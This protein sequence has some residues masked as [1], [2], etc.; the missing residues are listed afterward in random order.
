LK[1]IEI[2]GAKTFFLSNNLTEIGGIRLYYINTIDIN[3]SSFGYV[4][5]SLNNNMW[6]EGSSLEEINLSNLNNLRLL[7]FDY[8]STDFPL[9]LSSV[10]V[11]QL[12]LVN[13]S[14]TEL[15]LK[16]G[17]VIGQFQ[18]DYSS[19]VQFI[20]I[21]AD[22]FDEVSS[23]YGNTDSPVVIHPYCTFVLGGEYY[24]I[25]GNTLTDLGN[26]SETNTNG[27][28]FDIKFTVTD[29]E[30]TD[31]FYSDTSN[32]YS[33]TLPEGNHTLSSHLLN[34]DYWTVSPSSIDLD[35]PADGTPYVQDFCITP[36]GT[37]NDLEIVIVPI[38]DAQPGFE[39]NYKL[40]YKNS[41]TTILSGEINLNF[42]DNFTNFLTSSPNISNQTTGN[43]TWDYTDLLP[44]ETREISF[45]MLLNTPTDPD[46]PLNAEDVLTYTATINPMETDETSNNNT[47]TLNQ[48]V[49]N[50]FDPND[51]TCLEGSTIAYEQVGEY[52]HYR[53]RFENNGTANATNVVVKDILD[54]T[55]F[56][57]NSLVPINASHDFYT[58]IVNDNEVE[59]IFE[60]IQ[61]PFDNN[62]N[63][64]YILF[65][66]KTLPTLIMG[67]SFSNQ[68]EIFFDFNFPI[69]TNE[70]TTLIEEN[71]IT[72]DF[73]IDEILIF[74]NPTSSTL[75]I[76]ANT[77]MLNI[78]LYDISGK[79]LKTIRPHINNLEYSLN[80]KNLPNGIYFI[81]VQLENTIQKLKFIKN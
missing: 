73:N 8:F 69:L 25:T 61:L 44:F 70:E 31:T 66:I 81:E 40:I 21:D 35:F 75:N 33:Y 11:E 51:I 49:V 23:G 19:D 56:D 74:P 77:K 55:K 68:A 37:Y 38:N 34:L 43:L 46:F 6:I 30:S 14:L 79:L 13:C 5:S 7:R 36:T 45:S 9:D 80:V 27:P 72:T 47:F 67:D 52:V 48:I 10:E 63:D 26:G 50:S 42:N 20:C 24:E 17:D 62:N 18:C 1:D 57:L 28:I 12:S 76:K 64:G 59:F 53:I 71:L 4:N 22:E 16:N 32:N 65:K 41:G 15:N 54:T 29:G 2:S 58:R 39:A 3:D 78:Y 60:N